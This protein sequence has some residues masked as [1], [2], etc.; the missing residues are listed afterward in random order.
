MKTPLARRELAMIVKTW[1]ELDNAYYTSNNESGPIEATL[2]VSRCTRIRRKSGVEYTT[3]KREAVALFG[4]TNEEI[5]EKVCAFA[6]RPD[7]VLE[8]AGDED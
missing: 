1:T 5:D 7:V 3:R 2:L 8:E 6:E 4:D